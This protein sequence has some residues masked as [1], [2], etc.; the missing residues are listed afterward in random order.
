MDSMKQDNDSKIQNMN[1]LLKNYE[2][3]LNKK[4][5]VNKYSFNLN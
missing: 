3:L 4:V 5:N 1:D 2:Y